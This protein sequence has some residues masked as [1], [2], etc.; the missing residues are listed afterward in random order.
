MLTNH[1]FEYV[2]KRFCQHIREAGG[3]LPT[4]TDF[5]AFLGMI[6]NTI[7]ETTVDEVLLRAIMMY[8][9]IMNTD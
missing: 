8:D 5:R 2:Y 1:Q 6:S 3:T 4:R 7:T 9:G